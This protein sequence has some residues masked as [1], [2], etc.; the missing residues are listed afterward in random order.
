MPVNRSNENNIDKNK[1]EKHSLLI[2]GLK[3]RIGNR[4][5]RIRSLGDITSLD[6][7]NISEEKENQIDDVFETSK[8]IERQFN[9][10]SQIG[11]IRKRVRQRIAELGRE[12]RSN[13]IDQK[14]I[15]R[16]KEDLKELQSKERL[17]HIITRV[18]EEARQKLFDSQK[19]ASLFTE[20]SECD[21][22]VISVDIR[23]STELMLTAVSSELYAEFITTLTE[24]L[25]D[26]ITDNFGIFEKFTGDGVLAFF[27]DFYSGDDALLFALRTSAQ[28]HKVFID[29]FGLYNEYFS[30]DI[31]QTGL[32]IGIDT[33]RISLTTINGDLSIVGTP[34]VYACRYSAAPAGKTFLTERAYI[35]AK[36]VPGSGLQF[37][38]VTVEIKHEGNAPAYEIISSGNL[39]S[40]QKPDWDLLMD[41]YS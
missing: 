34:V 29:H 41:K 20:R 31:A 4:R 3:S 30:V 16:L 10:E 5:N 26:C 39:L 32:G 15:A 8:T 35:Q 14:F 1:R 37:S 36:D 38:P 28:C 27:P 22:F 23:R 40:L 7:D 11:E 12:L 25:S 18:N 33:G 24:K 21:A 19:F 13:S 6:I 2:S 17:K 9:L